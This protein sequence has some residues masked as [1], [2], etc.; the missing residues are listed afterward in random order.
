MIRDWD[1]KK[2]RLCAPSALDF[3]DYSDTTNANM[4]WLADMLESLDL[5]STTLSTCMRLKSMGFETLIIVFRAVI[6]IMLYLYLHL[7]SWRVLFSI[8]CNSKVKFA[9]FWLVY[10]SNKLILVIKNSSY[11]PCDQGPNTSFCP[12]KTL[13]TISHRR[14]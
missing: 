4:P 2:L 3:K 13:T 10:N 9:F 12:T 5:T 7:T 14:A 1:R 11:E 6:F 8:N